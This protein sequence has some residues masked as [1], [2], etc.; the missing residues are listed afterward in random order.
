VFISVESKMGRGQ[1]VRQRVLVPLFGG[2]NPS[3]PEHIQFEY[4]LDIRIKITLSFFY[5]FF[6]EIHFFYFTNYQNRIE[7]LFIQYRVN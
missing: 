4:K 5:Y 3:V 6:E 1:A 7:N 2:S